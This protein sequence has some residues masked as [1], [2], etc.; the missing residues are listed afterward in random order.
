M[1]HYIISGDPT[2]RLKVVQQKIH[3]DVYK[4]NLHRIRHDL[5]HQH[6][7]QPRLTGPLRLRIEF[8]LPA[9]KKDLN[10]G[11]PATD[12][13][14]LGDMVRFVEEVIQQILVHD[15]CIIVEITTIKCFDAKPRTELYFTE[16]K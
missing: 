14:F 13:P 8:Y 15:S 3:W 9:R 5:E 12:R 6:G 2:P 1:K 10:S 4:H 7:D 11:R 16:M